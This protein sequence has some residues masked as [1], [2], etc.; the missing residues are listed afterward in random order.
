M[1]MA[2]R[3]LARMHKDDGGDDERALPKIIPSGIAPSFWLC[4]RKVP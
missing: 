4:A 1:T 3:V 2:K